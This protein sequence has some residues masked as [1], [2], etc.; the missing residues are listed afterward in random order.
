[1]RAV[2]GTTEGMKLIV[3]FDRAY[4]RFRLLLLEHQSNFLEW[5]DGVQVINEGVG[6]AFIENVDEKNPEHFKITLAGATTKFEVLIETAARDLRQLHEHI[7]LV[8][9]QEKAENV[10]GVPTSALKKLQDVDSAL[11]IGR[12]WL[13][14]A[15]QFAPWVHEILKHL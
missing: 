4:E 13:C 14:R 8:E 3:D 6:A 11:E 10:T 15:I 12:K 9:G 5:Q 1:V 7:A 2:L